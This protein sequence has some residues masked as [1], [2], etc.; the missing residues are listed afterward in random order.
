MANLML[1]RAA[2]RE[3]ELAARVALGAGRGHLV[4]ILLVENLLLSVAG[5]VLGALFAKGLSASIVLFLDGGSGDLVLDLPIDWRVVTFVSIA[6]TLTSVLAGLAPAW[7]AADVAPEGVLRAGSRGGTDT[8]RRA[9]F[10]QAL[11]VAQVALSLA[12]LAGAVL[13]GRSLKNLVTQN[14]GFRPAGLTIAYVDSSGAKVPADRRAAF[15]RQVLEQLERTSGV[16]SVAETTVVPLSGT[17]LSNDVWLDQGGP[18]LVSKFMETGS[19]YFKTMETPLV[20]GRTFDDGRDGPGTPPVAVINEALAAALATDGGNPVGLRVR[21]EARPG[22][23]EKVFEVIGV[24]KNAKYHNLR[25]AMPPTMYLATAQ[26]PNPGTFMQLLIRTS[27]EKLPTRA[28]IE[29]TLREAFRQASPAIGPSFADF[30]QMITRSLT[31]DQL[32]A[33]LSGF[34]GLLAVLLAVVGVYGAQSFAVAR[35]TKEI[36]LRMAL[37]ADRRGIR[38][39]VM[40]DA[41]S[42]VILGCVIG[43]GLAFLLARTVAALAFNVAPSDPWTTVWAAALLLAAALGASVGPA[44]RA[45]KLDPMHAVRAD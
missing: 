38:R 28:S 44:R 27:P 37:G 20:A 24:V 30:D 11:V 17:S 42:V 39:M 41:A 12:L 36:G 15:K 9:R 23:S 2:T 7:R 4:R 14:L 19:S 6:A 34:F 29:S 40:R 32:L 18:R 35:R 25:Q 1:A 21:R 26:D 45:A 31:Q 16:V 43:G 10:R 8:R 3:R 5:A 33:G 13:F 22:I